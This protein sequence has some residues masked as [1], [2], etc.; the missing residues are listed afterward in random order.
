MI[1]I[2][3]DF[4]T[5]YQQISGCRIRRFCMCGFRVNFIWTS[6]SAK[7]AKCCF[8]KG[9]GFRPAGLSDSK[10]FRIFCPKFVVLLLNHRPAQQLIDAFAG[11]DIALGLFDVFDESRFDGEALSQSHI[12]S[13]MFHTISG[14]I[15]AASGAGSGATDV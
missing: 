7:R 8:L 12:F 10:E 1:I 13:R 5:R 11:R 3:C 2:G 4:H 15:H 14:P 9:L 6:I